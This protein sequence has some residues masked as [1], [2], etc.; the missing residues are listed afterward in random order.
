MLSQMNVRTLKQRLTPIFGIFGRA[1]TINSSIDVFRVCR[2]T[3]G[4]KI[5]VRSS[6]AAAT[7]LIW[8]TVYISLL[9]GKRSG[10]IQ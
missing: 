2:Q 5:D 4:P 1:M 7:N 9:K 10:G 8:K 3:S 6:A